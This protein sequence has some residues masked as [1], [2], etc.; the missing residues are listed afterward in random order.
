[1]LFRSDNHAGLACRPQNGGFID[2][3]QRV[4]IDDASFVSK[5]RFQN[6]SRSHRLRHHRAASD[7][8][9]I[10]LFV[11]MVCGENRL[12]GIREVGILAAQTNHICLPELKRRVLVRHNR[13]CLASETDILRPAM[14]QQQIICRLFRLIDIT[15]NHD[16]HIRQTAHGEQVFQRLMCSPVRSYRHT[17]VGSRNQHVEVPIANRSSNLIQIARRR[18]RSIS[19]QHRQ[20]AFLCQTCRRRR[21]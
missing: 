8:G 13:R 6:P 19:A 3:L 17:S 14:L 1:M 10:L 5:I 2:R 20:F 16:R 12:E 11:L 15:R 9:Q 4:H 18:K 7:D 21:R